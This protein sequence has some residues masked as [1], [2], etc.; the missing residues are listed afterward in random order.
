MVMMAITTRSSIRV[1]FRFIAAS[2]LKW[3]GFVVVSFSEIVMRPPFHLNYRPAGA[4]K[5]LFHGGFSG[6]ARN[7]PTAFPCKYSCWC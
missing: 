3:F 5:L 1:N 6:S 7:A 4:G 2:Y